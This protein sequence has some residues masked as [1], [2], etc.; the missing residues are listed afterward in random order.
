[1]QIDSASDEQIQQWLQELEQQYTKIKDKGLKLDLTRG[2]PSPAQLDLANVLDGDL[3]GDYRSADGTDTRNYGG[4]DGL[5]EMKAFAGAILGVPAEEVLVGGGSSLTLMYQAIHFAWMFG[6]GDNGKS[7]RDEET[8][9]FLC[10]VPGYDRHFSITEEFG[11]EMINVPMNDNG[12]DMDV[13]ERLIAEDK[14]I[15]GIWC[16]PKYSN[17]T[18]CIYSAETVDR[19]ARLGKTAAVNFRI[20][21]DNA[22]AVHDLDKPKNLTSIRERCSEHGTLESVYQ[23]ASTSKVTFA[24]QACRLWRQHL[25]T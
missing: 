1:M 2:K 3:D 25:Q 13:V 12:P 6:V 8:V 24:G 17:P 16:V 7:W 11:I 10:P 15:K 20:F 23:F 18:G 5:P 14:T 4:L 22:Y 21:W 9:K 19:I